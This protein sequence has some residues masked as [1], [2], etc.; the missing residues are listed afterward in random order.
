MP[1]SEPLLIKVKT[2]PVLLSVRICSAAV[3]IRSAAVLGGVLPSIAKPPSVKRSAAVLGGVQDV[4][5][6]PASLAESLK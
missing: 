3:P 2:R 1:G 5:A 6:H 4:Y